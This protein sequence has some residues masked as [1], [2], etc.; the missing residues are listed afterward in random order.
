M[1]GMFSREKWQIIDKI[2]NLFGINL[3]RVVRNAASVNKIYLNDQKSNF[4]PLLVQFHD[5]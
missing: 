4:W 3:L 1:V 2:Y 5:F